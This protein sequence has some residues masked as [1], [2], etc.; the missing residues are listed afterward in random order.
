MTSGLATFAAGD[1]FA[2]ATLLDD[3]NDDHAGKGRVIHYDA[4]LRE[5][6]VLTTPGTTHLVSGLKFDG[7][8]RLWAFDSQAFVVLTIDAQGHIERPRFATRPF[9]NVNFF[10]DGSVLLGEHLVG[11]QVK[12]EI[13]ARMGTRLQHMPGAE[14]FGDGHVFKYSRAGKLL[15]EYAT[16]THGGMT[17]F[18]GVTAAVLSADESILYYA[19]ETGPRLMRY[20]LVNDRQLPDLLAFPEGQRQMFF[21]LAFA[22]DG[23]LLVS[24][25]ARIDVLDPRYATVRRSL[26]LEGVGWATI[27]AAGDGRT[28]FAG[29]FFTGELVRVDATS[30]AK[31]ASANVGV[32]K[33]LAGIAVFPG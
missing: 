33:S 4:D 13:A 32:A 24:R 6:G 25:G 16:Q 14:R 28:I 1:V 5:K 20:D 23:A 7:R 26:P 31:L 30:G 18:L 10:R 12:P 11:S 15:K 17:G 29:N 9:S 27:A 8:G 2:A 3:P 22:A 19:S 21:G